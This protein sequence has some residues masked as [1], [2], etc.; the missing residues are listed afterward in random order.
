MARDA[1]QQVDP[2]QWGPRTMVAVRSGMSSGER[3]RKVGALSAHLQIISQSMQAG[4]QLSD[5]RRLYAL[6][7]DLGRAQELEGVDQYYL[8]PTSQEAQQ[9]SQ[10]AQQAAQ[11]Q[12][13]LQLQLAQLGDQVKLA[14]AKL[15]DETDRLRIA[16]DLEAKEAELYVQGYTKSLDLEQAKQ[17]ADQA[18]R[19]GSDDAEAA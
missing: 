6:L 7:M 18:T 12:Q 11:Q 19:R 4:M 2:R 5:T 14:I 8:D 10:Q 3:N 17:S 15:Q 13:Q 9:V 16:A 1:G